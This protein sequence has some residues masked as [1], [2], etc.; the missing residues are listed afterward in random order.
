[1]AIGLFVMPE[2]EG[3]R[4]VCVF[5]HILDAEDEANGGNFTF[6]VTNE[7]IASMNPQYK[8]SQPQPM[9]AVPLKPKQ[10]NKR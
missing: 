8:G 3:N 7:Q 9:H 6:S 1:M 2:T 4:P 10:E 5:D